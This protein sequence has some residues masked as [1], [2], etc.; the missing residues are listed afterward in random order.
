LNDGCTFFF[1]ALEFLWAVLRLQHGYLNR[2]IS[3][4]PTSQTQNAQ[5]RNTDEARDLSTVLQLEE[6]GVAGGVNGIMQVWS[7]ALLL[8]RITHDSSASRPRKPLESFQKPHKNSF[9]TGSDSR[10]RSKT[11]DLIDILLR[12]GAQLYEEGQ[13]LNANLN[14]MEQQNQSMQQAHHLQSPQN[15]QILLSSNTN[16]ATNVLRE[17]IQRQRETTKLVLN[18]LIHINREGLLM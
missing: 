16:I 3:N 18:S 4:D 10:N 6:N 11:K 7:Q 2:I 15:Q 9:K 12:E 13:K 14:G 8:N 5:E 17:S 1:T